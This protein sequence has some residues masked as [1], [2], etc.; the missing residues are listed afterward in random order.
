MGGDIVG[1]LKALLI[2]KFYS[3]LRHQAM[4]GYMRA[5]E[6]YSSQSVFLWWLVLHILMVPYSDVWEEQYGKVEA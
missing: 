1:N 2:D 4:H 3:D 5:P 6:L